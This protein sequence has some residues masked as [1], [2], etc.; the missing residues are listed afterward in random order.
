MT[1][2]SHELDGGASHARV[3]AR[4]RDGR[5]FVRRHVVDGHSMILK[6]LVHRRDEDSLTREAEWFRR[7]LG[8]DPAADFVAIH[9][10]GKNLV[11]RL[12]DLGTDTLQAVLARRAAAGR[13]FSSAELRELGRALFHALDRLQLLGIAH[14]A[15]DA[16]HI[17]V[18]SESFESVHLVGFREARELGAVASESADRRRSDCAAALRC[19][20]IAATYHEFEDDAATRRAALRQLTHDDAPI[21]PEARR[22]AAFFAKWGERRTTLDSVQLGEAWRAC[23][24]D[25][26]PSG[27]HWPIPNVVTSTMLSALF[28]ALRFARGMGCVVAPSDL[29][30]GLTFAALRIR[31]AWSTTP[32]GRSYV[33]GIARSILARAIA[34]RAVT[35]RT[36]FAFG[37]PF[38]WYA[39][40]GM[41]LAPEIRRLAELLAKFAS[42]AGG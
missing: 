20:F 28:T 10:V 15:I 24:G 35:L 13:R 21:A 22:V 42:P 33:R 1:S 32:F 6:A 5:S 7:S 4:S 29:E 26:A 34:N 3:V 12:P 14:R 39:V 41:E 17:V 9:R 31:P 38:P 27:P 36:S 16:S 19:L 8:N 30:P 23:F 18:S 37:R 40:E 2:T 25:D 11:L